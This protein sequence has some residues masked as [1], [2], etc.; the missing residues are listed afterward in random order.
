MT[1]VPREVPGRR[2]PVVV[3]ICSIPLAAEA[4]PATVETIRNVVVGAIYGR[5][6]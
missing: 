2:R 5:H 1:A 6:A 3:F 4:E